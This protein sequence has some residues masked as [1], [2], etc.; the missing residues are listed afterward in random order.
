MYLFLIQR[1]LG[2]LYFAE[3]IRADFGVFRCC[4]V[5]QL[6]KNNNTIRGDEVTLRT[7]GT[8]TAGSLR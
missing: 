1:Y 7:P 8:C 4:A 5:K 3:A 6:R 2:S